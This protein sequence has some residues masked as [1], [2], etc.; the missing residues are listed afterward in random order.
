M[1]IILYNMYKIY[2]YVLY[3]FTVDWTDIQCKLSCNKAQAISQPNRWQCEQTACCHVRQLS[4][5]LAV[6]MLPNLVIVTCVCLF[7]CVYVCDQETSIDTL[8][9]HDKCLLE[10][11]AYC[12]FIHFIF[13]QRCLLD[14]LSRKE[15]AIPRAH[16]SIHAVVP[17]GSPGRFFTTLQ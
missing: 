2:S 14:L 12:S 1:I 11:D 16:V 7:V 17:R 8:T 10:K 6:C 4:G 9:G 13:R 3:R 15:S 5:E